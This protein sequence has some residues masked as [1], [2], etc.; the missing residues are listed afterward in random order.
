M[1]KQR[2]DSVSTEIANREIFELLE[3]IF[4]ANHSSIDFSILRG[5]TGLGKFIKKTNLGDKLNS[6]LFIKKRHFKIF[7]RLMEIFKLKKSYQH[8][9]SS[10]ESF[11]INPNND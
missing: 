8:K 7:W 1:S 4:R 10:N 2:K 3:A 9:N 5:S 6:P 11:L